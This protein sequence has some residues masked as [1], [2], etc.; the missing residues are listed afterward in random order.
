[1]S[2]LETL[3]K[4]ILKETTDL[5]KTSV[6]DIYARTEISKSK[7]ITTGAKTY[8][9]VLSMETKIKSELKNEKKI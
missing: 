8:L 6:S 4:I 1:M 2:D 3:R 9:S 5:S 7:A